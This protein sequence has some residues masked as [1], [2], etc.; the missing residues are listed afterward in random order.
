MRESK[1]SLPRWKVR[2]FWTLLISSVLLGTIKILD[3]AEPGINFF[4]P[5]KGYSDLSQKEALK[6]SMYHV[7]FD[8]GIQVDWISGDSQSKTVRIP[9]DLSPV[10]PYAALV[11]KFRELG[12]NILKAESSPHGDK[13]VLEVGINKAPLFRLTLVE[14]SKLERVGGKI[15]VV[16]DDFG[17][18][19]GS[20]V[21]GFLG[22]D[23]KVTFSIIPG[24][25]KSEEVAKVAHEHGREVMIHL[26]MEPQNGNFKHDEYI[27]L[28]TMPPDEIRER[29]RSAIWSVPHARGL[30]NHMGSKATV[31][32]QL[33]STL[34]QEVEKAG[35]FFLDSRTNDETIAYS[36]AQNMKIPSGMNNTFLDAIEEEPFI[37]QQLYF[38]AEIASRRGFA[39]G[40]G[41]PKQLTLKVLKEE[42]RKLEKKGYKFVNMSEVVR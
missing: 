36:M 39:I 2:L 21:Q 9:K 24:L 8:F 40:I 34:M 23:Q 19:S 1:T 11:S 14:D 3:R 22:L 32:Q 26:P 17:Y 6:F 13:M 30:N 37:R 42:M 41:H 28:T 7:L 20:L 29:V 4:P 31:N 27:L 25:K 18:D 35:L 10:T 38:L 16:I 5:S 12:G 15:A 33:L